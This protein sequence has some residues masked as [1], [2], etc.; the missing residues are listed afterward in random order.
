MSKD[1]PPFDVEPGNSALRGIL[2]FDQTSWLPDNLL[3]RAD[4]MTMAAS[5]ESRVPFLD[6]KFAEFVSALPDELRVR[7][8]KG[9]RILREAA[10]KLLP[11]RILKRP[12][13]G[14]RVPVNEWFR[15]SMRGFLM[16]HLSS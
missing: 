14:F 7:G 2:Y 13:V 16:D 15:G 3:D 1:A 8:M 4:R 5:I 11:Q 12:K 9:K 6:H 10:K